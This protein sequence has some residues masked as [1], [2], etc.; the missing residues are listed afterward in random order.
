M[1]GE[2]KHIKILNLNFL[3]V[4]S[5][6]IWNVEKFYETLVDGARTKQ[7]LRAIFSKKLNQTITHFSY[8]FCVAP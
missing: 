6:H 5:S 3:V 4:A 1:M 7:R 8:V 2:L